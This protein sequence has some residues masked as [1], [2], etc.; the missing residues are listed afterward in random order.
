MG[1]L[2]PLF[3]IETPPNLYRNS[4][5]VFTV[6]WVPSF[7]LVSLSTLILMVSRSERSKPWKICC[8][9]VFCHG[10]VAGRIILHWQ[11][12]LITTTTRLASRWHHLRLYMAGSVSPLCAGRH[13]E[14]DPWLVLIGFS[15]L[16]RRFG[17]FV[18]IF[19]SIRAVRRVMLM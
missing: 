1:C 13:W 5:R 4:G 6:H 11:S 18:R 14:R 7:H 3:L 12:L 10:R 2:S 15:R 16:L 17:K 19:W 8:V 9:L